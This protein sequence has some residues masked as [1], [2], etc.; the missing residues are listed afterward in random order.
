MNF[1]AWGASKQNSYIMKFGS[2]GILNSGNLYLPP[3]K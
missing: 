1:G 3:K 2:W